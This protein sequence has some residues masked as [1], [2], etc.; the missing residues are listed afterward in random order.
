MG[1]PSETSS[2]RRLKHPLFP[3]SGLSANKGQRGQGDAERPD[4]VHSHQQTLH[5]TQGGPANDARRNHM[6][7]CF[8]S[9]QVPGTSTHTLQAGYV[10]ETAARH[11]G[12]PAAARERAHSVPIATS[13]LT[14]QLVLKGYNSFRRGSNSSRSSVPS[15]HCSRSRRVQVMRPDRSLRPQ[16]LNPSREATATSS[17]HD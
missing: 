13:C 14:A 7:T 4:L 1:P 17:M 16:I 11:Q 15:S 3:E 10:G 8:P 6:R 5:L 9:P 12:T 2:D